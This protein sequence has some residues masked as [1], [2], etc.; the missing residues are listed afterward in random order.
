MAEKKV[1]I[2]VVPITGD[3]V[4]HDVV[5]TGKGKATVQKAL[6]QAGVSPDKKSI[7]VVRP[8]AVTLDL[9]DEIKDGET[10]TVTELP[11]GS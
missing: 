10:I 2:V 7:T 6:T 1:K 11:Q 4:T 3:P 9:R 8:T 5:V